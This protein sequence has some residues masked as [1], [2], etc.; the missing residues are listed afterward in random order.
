MKVIIVGAGFGG[1]TVANT[2]KNSDFEVLIIERNNYH[3]FQPLLYQVAVSAL[4]PGDIAYPIRA[5]F[6]KSRNVRILMDE[7]VE[8][9]LKARRLIVASGDAFEYDYLVLAPGAETTYFG[10][11][12]WK[13]FTVPLKSLPDALNIREKIL[14]TFEKAE[15][16]L[17]RNGDISKLLTFVL[18][19]GGPTG[20]ELSGA[21]S[22]LIYKTILP[23]F[24]LLKN[25]KIKVIL[26]DAG[27]RLLSSYPEELSDY[28]FESLSALGVEIHLNTRVVNIQNE[29]VETTK[30]KFFASNI[31]W[32]AGNIASPLLN[33]LK[34]KLDR[35]GR[36]I[37]NPDLSIPGFPDAFVIGDAA[38]FRINE[39]E[40]LPAIAPVAIQQGEHVGKII[41]ERKP[42]GLR[43]NF[44]YRDKGTMATIGK[45]R[46]V[47]YLKGQ[48]FK[49]WFAWLL[50]SFVHIL[51]LIG[52][53]NKIRVM[54][55]WMWYYVT[56]KS[57][58]RLIVNVFRKNRNANS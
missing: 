41:L 29:I 15:K 27:K 52:F 47:A 44:L 32:V 7:V 37:V 3:L 34:V 17:L 26:I 49:G 21:I 40:S 20:V 28:T 10:N 22:E 31:F 23:D 45:A 42:F 8:V 4:S 24:P 14:L 55:E 35:Q 19:G 16:M 53:R 1:L 50:W 2:L 57:G 58:A 6:R 5:I 56:N 54:L 43:P 48:S 12:E 11:E 51:F 46:A 9:D 39:S 13:R 36:V 33:S 38:S 30:G 25:H 18:V